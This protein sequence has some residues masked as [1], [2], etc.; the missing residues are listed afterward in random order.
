MLTDSTG[1]RA[2]DRETIVLCILQI[3]L[4]CSAGMHLIK[5]KT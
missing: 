2:F 3:H 5:D 1:D 4:S